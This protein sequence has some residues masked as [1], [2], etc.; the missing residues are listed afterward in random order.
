MAEIQNV[1]AFVGT[2]QTVAS[3]TFTNVAGAT[4]TVPADGSYILLCTA[5]VG[6]DHQNRHYWFRLAKDGALLGSSFGIL[7]PAVSS[8][9]GATPQTRDHY[10][11]M[12]WDNTYSAGEVITFQ[13]LCTAIGGVAIADMIQIVLIRTDVDLTANDFKYGTNS[14]VTD[15]TTSGVNFADTGLFTPNGTDDWLVIAYGM[16]E[17]GA[18]RTITMSINR[19]SGAEIEPQVSRETEDGVERPNWVTTRTFKALSATPHR[20]QVQAQLNAT[21]S[22]PPRHF[23]SHIFAIRL[24]RFERHASDY[25]SATLGIGGPQQVNSV[26][27]GAG[28]SAAALYLHG[29]AVSGG[30]GASALFW[31]EKGGAVTPTNADQDNQGVAYDARD[32]PPVSNIYVD[33]PLA[34]GGATITSHADSTAAFG[35]IFHRSLTVFSLELPATGDQTVFLEAA[36]LTATGVEPGFSFGGIN[37]AVEAA[38]LT[39][40]APALTPAPGNLDTAVEAA[41]VA[42]AGVDPTVALG[43]INVAVEVS[44]LALSAPAITVDTSGPQTIPV[45]AA[46]LSLSAPAITLALGNINV[47]VEAASLTASGVAITVVPVLTVAVEAASLTATAPALGG[48]ALGGINVSVEASNLTLQAPVITVDAGAGV[49]LVFFHHTL[50]IVNPATDYPPGAVYTLEVVLSQDAVANTVLCRLY[51]FTDGIEIPASEVSTTNTSPT[52]LESGAITLTAGTKSYRAYF[53]GE[54]GGEYRCHMARIKVRN[55]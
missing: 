9:P 10:G 52:Q 27:V 5:Q 6:G 7:E 45:E 11:Y 47:A 19:D 13:M 42:L 38:S 33:A 34:A 22:I 46:S 41:S 30:L 49:S 51:N 23:E 35:G 24:N 54:A 26:T 12:E 37:V 29:G 15:L 40:Q 31:T 44:S 14:T 1:R 48:I 53:G 28:T 4:V 21:S 20:F 17:A 18:S 8:T 25:V 50:G 16:F 32:G 3:T 36:S 55:T 43:N 39:A 2:E